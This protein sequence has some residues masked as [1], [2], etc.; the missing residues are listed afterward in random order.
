MMLH[1]DQEKVGSSESHPG[2]VL[3]PIHAWYKYFPVKL[4]NSFLILDAF[5]ARLALVSV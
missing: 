2:E 1:S 3:S 4:Y 5:Q